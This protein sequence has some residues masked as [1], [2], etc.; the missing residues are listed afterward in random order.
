[1]IARQSGT[2]KAVQE[3]KEYLT[4]PKEILTL[5]HILKETKAALEVWE[6]ALTRKKRPP[7]QQRRI[8]KRAK[9]CPFSL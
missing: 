2:T 8:P 7:R 6:H 1:M 4:Y 3:A 5:G 9:A